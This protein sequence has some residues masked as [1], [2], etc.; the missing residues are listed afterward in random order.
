MHGF[1]FNVNTD[2]R[3]FDYIVPCGIAEKAVTSMEKELGSKQN[4]LEVEEILK[5]NLRQQFGMEWL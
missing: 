2:L 3:Y 1:A 5:E 4:M